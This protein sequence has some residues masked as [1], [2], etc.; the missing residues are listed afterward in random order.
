MENFSLS[1]LVIPKSSFKGS[2]SHAAIEFLSAKWGI[3]ESP[4]VDGTPIFA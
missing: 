4:E 3:F 2:K 1:Q